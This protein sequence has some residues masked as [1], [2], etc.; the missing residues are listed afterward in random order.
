MAGKIV[1]VEEYEETADLEK[2]EI[3]EPE[4]EPTQ[5]SEQEPE[6]E[7]EQEI[8]EKYRGKSVAEIARMHQEA[9]KLLGRQSQEVG[10]L[11]KAF[12]EFVIN[13]S[14][15]SVPQSESTDD[16]EVDFFVNPKA[17]VSKA[18]ESHPEFKEVRQLTAEMKKTQ[19]LSRLNQEHPD[20]KNIVSDNAFQQ[21]VAASKFRQNLFI[22]ADSQYDYEAANE[23]LTLWKERQQV[24]QQ[25]KNVEQ[26]AQRQEL[27]RAATG[28]TRS[29]PD[30]QNSKKVY[31]R[32]DIR[33]LMSEN[34]DRYQELADEIL[35]AYKEGRVK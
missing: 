3:A 6:Q 12:D 31:R 22:Q 21:W 8:P 20:I 10:E 26:A 24:V 15:K 13:Q 1:E 18:I 33:K 7:P 34:P 19:A 30:G 17:S 23:L 29:N 27:K 35:L 25:T 2:Q 5:E 14:Q 32:A 11:R 9:E 28:S 16:D 4:Q